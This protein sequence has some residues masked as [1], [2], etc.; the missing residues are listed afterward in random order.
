M[1]VSPR[2]V[3]KMENLEPVEAPEAGVWMLFTLLAWHGCFKLAQPRWA[4]W[5]LQVS[6][7]SAVQYHFLVQRSLLLGSK[8]FPKRSV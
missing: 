6:G 8:T 2:L 3:T 4:A 5:F 7:L 1:G